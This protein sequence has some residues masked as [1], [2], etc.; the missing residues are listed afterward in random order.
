MTKGAR[1]P[2]LRFGCLALLVG[3]AG[4]DPVPPE[5]R[6]PEILR[7]SLGLGEDDAVFEVG[8]AVVDG[9]ETA[10]PLSIDLSRPGWLSFRS[11]DRRTRRVVLDTAGLGPDQRGWMDTRHV[12]S[13]PLLH[14]E[15]RWVIDFRDAPA[16]SWSFRI[17]GSATEGRVRV[18]VPADPD[19]G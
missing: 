4:C 2:L 13:P 11:D 7:D 15:A 16:G 17:I 3:I 8:L 6:P 1:R 10:S 12:A 9:A 18:V 5:L 19:G 14:P